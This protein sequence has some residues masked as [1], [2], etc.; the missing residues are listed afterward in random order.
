MKSNYVQV[1]LALAV[2]PLPEM[3]KLVDIYDLGIVADD[4]DP[5]SFA[6]KLNLLTREEID[7][8]KSQ[9]HKHSIEL[10]A[11]TNREK[12]LKI[13][14]EQLLQERPATRRELQHSAGG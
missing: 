6:Q 7:Y 4:F 10:G 9:S 13:I 2:S 12:F 1:R 5:K 8:Y 14:D 3:K 11:E